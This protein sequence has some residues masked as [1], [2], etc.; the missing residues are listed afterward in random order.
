MLY[1]GPSPK[2]GIKLNSINILD[3][4]PADIRNWI[5]SLP[6][7]E[8]K[9]IRAII[10]SKMYPTN[11]AVSKNYASHVGRPFLEKVPYMNSENDGYP[12]IQGHAGNCDGKITYK[13]TIY[14]NKPDMCFCMWSKK[15]FTNNGLNDPRYRAT[16]KLPP[17]D[18]KRTNEFYRKNP[19]LK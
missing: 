17:L 16:N 3:Y 7:D 9:V 13:S 4:D 14:V 10:K 1:K 6:K 11:F 8:A 19:H 2:A 5:S 18:K 15:S 12:F